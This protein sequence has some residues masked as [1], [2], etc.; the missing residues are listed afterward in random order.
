M[1]QELKKPWAGKLRHSRELI[2]DWGWIRDESGECIM[3][4]R[5]P[6]EEDCAEKLHWHRLSNTDPTQV[7]VDAILALLNGE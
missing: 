5:I 2:D 3:M 4:I 7:R 1:T 6:Q